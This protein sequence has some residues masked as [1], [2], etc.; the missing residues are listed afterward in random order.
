MFYKSR[1]KA[2]SKNIKLFIVRFCSFMTIKA[3]KSDTKVDTLE[4]TKFKLSIYA[5]NSD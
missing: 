2:I 4:D 5:T 3:H 1:T